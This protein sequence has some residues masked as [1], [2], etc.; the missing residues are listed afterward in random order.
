M[1]RWGRAKCLW[2]RTSG[3]GSRE[4]EN[5]HVGGQ[6]VQLI[7]AYLIKILTQTQHAIFFVLFFFTDV[8]WKKY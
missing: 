5:E 1:E 8:K 2:E 6:L 3:A 4:N 7:L